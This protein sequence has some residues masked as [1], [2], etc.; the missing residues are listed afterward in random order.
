MNSRILLVVGDKFAS[1][2]QGK[3]A[4]TL[5]Q[6]RGLL[7][8]SVPLLPGQGVTLLVPG[9]G[10]GDASVKNL[11]AEAAASPNLSQFDFTL[12]HSLPERA[13]SHL[14]HKHLSSNT[15]VSTPRQ[16]SEFVYEADL[17]IDEDCELMH[18]HLSGQH[19]QGMILIEAIRQALM[20][21]AEAYLIPKNDIRYAFVFNGLS[22]TYSQYTFPIG[23]TIRCTMTEV[24]LD[25]P[26]RLSFSARVD[27]EQ[28]G[29]SVCEFSAS[30]GAMEKMRIAKRENMGAIKAH[31]EYLN[32][33]VAGMR[34]HPL[35]LAHVDSL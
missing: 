24:S 21:V 18:D 8:F 23:A 28:C 30:F 17:M 15:L 6:L 9:Q 4:I 35:S 16:Q 20:A 12:W 13:P 1:Y 34:Q 3:D 22:V 33:V 10:L 5:S 31:T 19:V 25:N 7:S 29:Q 26:R 27:V 11:L 2:V 14:T 32:Q